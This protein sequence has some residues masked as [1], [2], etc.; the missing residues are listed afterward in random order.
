MGMR[1]VVKKGYFK[2]Y[3]LRKLETKNRFG[4]LYKEEGRNM[5]CYYKTYKSDICTY[6]RQYVCLMIKQVFYLWQHRIL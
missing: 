3:Y 6:E 4:Q 1:V 2:D 5:C